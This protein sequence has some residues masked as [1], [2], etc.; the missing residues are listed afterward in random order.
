MCIFL[1][2]EL[3]IAPLLGLVQKFSDLAG[4]KLNRE[5]NR[6]TMARQG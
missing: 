5:K 3:Q 6:R 4:P 1:K 2:D